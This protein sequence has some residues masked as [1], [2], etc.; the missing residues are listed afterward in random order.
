M[1]KKTIAAFF[2]LLVLSCAL[3]ACNTT[4]GVGEDISSGGSAISG[5]ATRAQQ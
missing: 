5:A 1:V 3:T 4:R 2:S